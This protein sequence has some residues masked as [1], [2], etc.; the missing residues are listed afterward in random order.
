MRHVFL[1]GTFLTAAIAAT[2]ANAASAVATYFFQDNL[3]AVQSGVPALTAVDPTNSSGFV[4]SNVNGVTRD[5]YA[6]NGTASP[7]TS[8]GGL[9]LGTSSLLTDP[10]KYSVDMVFEFSDRAGQYR[11]ILDVQNRQ[12]DNGLYVDPSNNLDIYPVAGSS[13]AWTNGVFHHMVMTVD[14]TTAPSTVNTY[15]DGVS[16]FSAS[17]DLLNLNLD[18]T[19]NPNQLITLFLDNVVGGGQGE[20]SSGQIALF[21]LWDGVLTPTEAQ[22]LAPEPASLSILAAGVL[23]LR[24]RRQPSR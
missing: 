14:H 23:L 11:R 12:S 21:R 22:T 1:C 24:R 18:P 6:F 15:L 3:N 9:T 17:T 2:N 20:W 7:V 13:A 4:S 16:Q 8:Q 5:V 10:A 19:S